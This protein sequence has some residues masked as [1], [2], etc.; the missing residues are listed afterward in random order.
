MLRTGQGSI[1]GCGRFRRG[2]LLASASCLERTDQLEVGKYQVQVQWQT[3]TVRLQALDFHFALFD[4][5]AGDALY[6]RSKLKRHGAADM[7]AVLCA[8]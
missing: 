1:D 2:G 7:V 8:E 4:R 6:A 5:A 3:F